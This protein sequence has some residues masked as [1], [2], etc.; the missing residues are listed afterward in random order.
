[1][2]NDCEV[3]LSYEAEDDLRVVARACV[4]KNDPERMKAVKKRAKELLDESKFK[5][6]E[7]EKMISLGEGKD[8]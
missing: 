4:I 1:M 3:S 7:A 8:I 6:E 2:R 5:K